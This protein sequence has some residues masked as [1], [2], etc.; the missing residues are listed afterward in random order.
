MSKIGQFARNQEFKNMGFGSEL[1]DQACK[2]I[3]EYSNKFGVKYIT[4]DSYLYARNFYFKNDFQ[5]VNKTNYKKLEVGEKR[6]PTSIVGMYKNVD[7][8]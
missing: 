8:I 6:N 7:Y 1:L 2:L 5:Y 3:K 4:V